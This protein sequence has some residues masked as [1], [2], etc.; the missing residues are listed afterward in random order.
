MTGVRRVVPVERGRF[1]SLQTARTQKE[2][3]KRG[4]SAIDA[5]TK[6]GNAARCFFF[7]FHIF[8]QCLLSFYETGCKVKLKLI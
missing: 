2:S 6:A 4:A 8:H 7:F 5:K 3:G 1:H